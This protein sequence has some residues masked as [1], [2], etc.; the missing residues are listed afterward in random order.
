M[1]ADQ[2]QPSVDEK[3]GALKP[4]LESGVLEPGA[5]V[6]ARTHGQRHEA[7]V[8]ADG[9]LH[10]SDGSVHKNPSRA[11]VA[12][13]GYLTNGWTFWRVDNDQGSVLLKE[14]REQAAKRAAT[15][16]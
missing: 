8:D 9:C 3:S 11:A 16:H 15:G 4:L 12:T 14:L 1:P 7:S 6:W 10:L 13:G 5:T 2:P